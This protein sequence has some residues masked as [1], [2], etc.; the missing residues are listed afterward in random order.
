[1]TG[2]FLYTGNKIE[3]LS[4]RAAEI[5]GSDTT[6][7]PFYKEIFLVQTKGMSV[8]LAMEMAKY[9]GI[10]A[11]YEFINLNQLTGKLFFPLAETY[12]LGKNPFEG[13]LK[14]IIMEE[15]RSGLLEREEF[16]PLKKYVSDIKDSHYA[17]LKLFQLSQKIA[18][19]YDQYQISRFDMIRKWNK[20]QLL[21]SEEKSNG[22]EKW[23][24]ILWNRIIKK[25]DALNRYDITNDLLVA[26]E[27]KDAVVR[28][29]EITKRL[30]IFGL[31][32]IPPI[33][34]ELLKKL[35][36]YIEVNLFLLNP[37]REFWFDIESDRERARLRKRRNWKLGAEI[38]DH[39][40]ANNTLLAN[41]GK[42]GKDFFTMLYDCHF[43]GEEDLFVEN[44][45]NLTVLK[46][47][48][49]DILNLTQS[50]SKSTPH[51]DDSIKI[52]SCH[53]KMRE[54][55]ILYDNLLAEFD[56]D[57]IIT[58]RDIIV[59]APDIAEY[60]PFI[61]A[62][63]GVVSDEKMKIPYRVTDKN[64]QSES[65]IAE[66][67]LEIIEFLSGRFEIS[68]LLTIMQ[69]GSILKKAGLSVD[70]MELIAQW[71][72]DTNVRWGIDAAFKKE[73]GSNG[74]DWNTWS[75]GLDRMM[76]GYCMYSEDDQFVGNILPYLEIEG[77]SGIILGKFMDFFD[78]LKKYRELFKQSYFLSRWSDIFIEM[79]GDFFQSDRETEKE[80]TYIEKMFENLKSGSSRENQII[81]NPTVGFEVVKSYLSEL[82]KEDNLESGFISGGVTFCSTKP[83]RS[84][85][86]RIIC[87][88]GMN[89]N[90]FPRK[91]VGSAI[92]LMN[93]EFRAGD[94]NP[95]N[96]DRYLFLETLLSA[97]DKLYISYIG[98]SIKDNGKKMPSILVSELLDYI[99]AGYKFE[100]DGKDICREIVQE[101]PLQPFSRRYF[102]KKDKLFSYSKENSVVFTA[103]TAKVAEQLPT[104]E[105]EDK[106]ITAELPFA[107]LISFFKNP[108]RYYITE[109]LKA[110][111]PEPMEGGSDWE[112]FDIDILSNYSITNDFLSKINEKKF[113][114][115]R[116]IE[117]LRAKGVLPHGNVG[118]LKYKQIVTESEFF[119]KK[120]NKYISG[121]K[122]PQL[123]INKKI[124]INGVETILSGSIDDVYAA[125]LVKFRPVKK[126]KAKDFIELWLNHL[127]LLILKENSYP[128]KSMFFAGET[129]VKKNCNIEFNYIE[130]P[131]EKLEKLLAVYA[132][133][134]KGF[135]PFHPELSKPFFDEYQKKQNLPASYNKAL[136]VW[137]KR[138]DNLLKDD[139][140]LSRCLKELNFE[141]A[142]E[143]LMVEMRD[144]ALL[145]FEDMQL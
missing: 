41:S 115:E 47:I 55:E 117:I 1:M 29:R 21:Y 12:K 119:A 34:L 27:Q 28:V 107:K 72:K 97:R 104:E 96:S 102:D 82:M 121:G 130:N 125:A 63:F 51:D 56:A 54:I 105:K 108:A 126:E 109:I 52:I 133:G 49:N 90:A 39:L 101:H 135:I 139:N 71:L 70:D 83:M 85:P 57:D 25:Y 81:C 86:F 91:N 22:N 59:M 61:D 50:V 124:I 10:F 30:N 24:M 31:S 100:E 16:L 9:G 88:L 113:A 73:V 33:Y 77:K 137:Q 23:Q 36:N 40:G 75:A 99:S 123:S 6:T 62:V 8:W 95:K 120:L 80:I 66:C 14:W 48:Q 128:E 42:T 26:L 89:D 32:V 138:Y 68:P 118:R 98:R 110:R 69:N 43:S 45:E 116:E 131:E 17:E 53:S 19:S 112:N 76:S 93:V 74:E 60:A 44:Q 145:V 87:L 5:I 134:I 38:E 67:Y 15:L 122:L 106:A 143:E 4:R 46:N 58:P 65:S 103:D 92:D 37:C 35:A 64:L 18:D 94:R 127:L 141:N 136:A 2:M 142:N 84:I 3:E 144:L 114:N 11:N 78:L 132:R 13:D 7:T 111:Y 20:N 79:L 140:Y 129:P